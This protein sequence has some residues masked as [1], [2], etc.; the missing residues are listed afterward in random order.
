MVVEAALRDNGPGPVDKTIAF[1]MKLVDLL[2]H[3]RTGEYAA[4]S[5]V[6]IV[7]DIRI[8]RVSVSSGIVEIPDAAVSASLENGERLIQDNRQAFLDAWQEVSNAADGVSLFRID[9][10]IWQVA[11]DIFDNRG[12]RD[13]A[14]EAVLST[15][16]PLGLPSGF[17][18]ELA[19]CLTRALV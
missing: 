1:A 2:H 7:L 8:A 19:W 12:R 10:L 5:N 18:Q 4:L 9:S 14:R 6:P 15:L 11:K 3:A 16:K 17:R 13:A